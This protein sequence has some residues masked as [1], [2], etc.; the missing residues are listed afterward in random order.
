M[1]FIRDLQPVI[2]IMSPGI[3]NIYLLFNQFINSQMC[4][5]KDTIKF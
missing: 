1:I 4:S 2:E 3:V 5:Y